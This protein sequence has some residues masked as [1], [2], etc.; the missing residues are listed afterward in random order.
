MK[1]PVTDMAGNLEKLG[2]AWG[3]AERKLPTQRHTQT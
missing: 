2:L 1:N 3:K